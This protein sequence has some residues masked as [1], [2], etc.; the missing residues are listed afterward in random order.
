MKSLLQRTTLFLIALFLMPVATSNAQI[1]GFDFL[2]G[3]TFNQNDNG[4]A[5]SIGA[6]FIE[7]TNGSS[8]ARTIWFDTRQPISEFCASFR[9]RTQSFSF[10]GGTNGI[11]F[12]I[13][14]DPRGLGATTNS[15]SGGGFSGIDQS[16]GFVFDLNNGGTSAVSF[17]QNGVIGSG[18][19]GLGARTTFGDG[20]DV[21]LRYDGTLLEVLID[22]GIATPFSQTLFISPAIADVLESGD[23]IIGFGATSGVRQTISNFSF[24]GSSIIPGDVNQDCVVNFADIA[25]FITLLTLG[26]F[27]VQADTNGDNEVNFADIA[28]FITLLTD[29]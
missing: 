3:Y 4:N 28:P 11:S 9:Y 14:N 2:R 23:A 26:E 22:D 10:N 5:P 24:V 13:H 25:P 8:Q 12:I 20:L 16:V 27:Q 19:T 7:I 18:G 15:F 21:T 6:D 17:Q 29:N 1:D